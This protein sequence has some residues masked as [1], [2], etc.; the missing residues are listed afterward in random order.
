MELE[1]RI[2][3]V[4]FRSAETG[5]CVATLDTDD[6]EI[7]VVGILPEVRQGETLS[8]VGELVFHPKYGDQFTVTQ[9]TVRRPTSKHAIYSYLASGIIDKIGPRTAEAIVDLFGEDTLR[10]MKDHPEQLLKV[11]GIGK[12]TLA[13]ITASFSAQEEGREVMLFLQSLGLTPNL[14]YRIYKEYGEQTREILTENPYRMTMDIDGI[15]FKKADEIARLNQMNPED[16][17]RLKAG[18]HYLLQQAEQNGGH[19]ALPEPYLLRQAKVLLQVDET[20]LKEALFSLRLDTRIHYEEVEG[21]A[22]CYRMEAF[23]AERDIAFSLARMQNEKHEELEGHGIQ[24]EGLGEEQVEGIRMVLSSGVSIITGGPGTGK[25]TLLRTLLD[26]L[27]EQKQDAVLCAPTGRAA[28]RMEESTGHP[29]ATI[30]R[31]LGYNPTVFPPYEFDEENPIDTDWVIVDESSMLDV[32][33]MDRLLKALRPDTRVLFVGDV[34]QLPSVGAGNV[35]KDLIES[36]EIP[37]KRLTQIYRQA[38]E[39]AIVMNAHRMQKGE[40]PKVNEPGT[41]FF[42]MKTR[43]PEHTVR[44]IAQLLTVRLPEAYGVDPMRDIQVLSPTKKQPTGI[45]RLNEALQEALNPYTPAKRQIEMRGVI[46]RE[47]DRVMQMRN[48]Y[49][50]TV[51]DEDENLST[52]VFNGDLGQIQ[53]VQDDALTVEF[54]D[55]SRVIYRK[56]EMEDLQHA[57]AITIHKS[58]GSEFP[59]VVI[60][61]HRGPM[62]LYTRNLLYTAITRAKKLVV[63]VGDEEV[64]REMIANTHQDMRYTNLR[65]RLQQA[66]GTLTRGISI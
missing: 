29:A 58:Q 36:K 6:G 9:A 4:R 30:H 60:P 8:V 57:Y 1:G 16:S 18:I 51:T 33:L 32:F 35:L 47:G 11:R 31:L 19:C 63:L 28:K 62:M 34:D 7:T 13:K 21:I 10:I 56:K 54:D 23:E 20:L 14:S 48:N 43:H 26:I 5:F 2:T 61:M 64:M 39:S 15:G 45:L 49:E 41:D 66:V 3:D 55:G 59:I 40:L 37:V 38:E 50:I 12:K 53:S 65:F 46:L 52:G 27:Q 42:F 44:L 22:Y 25:T 24:E 17:F